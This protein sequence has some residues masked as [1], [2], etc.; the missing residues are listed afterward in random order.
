[1]H[2]VLSL[3]PPRLALLLT[4]CATSACAHTP[5]PVAAKEPAPMTDPTAAPAGNPHLSVEEVGKRFLRLLDSIHTRDDITKERIERVMGVPL[6][7]ATDGASYYIV[8]KI[9]EDWIFSFNF[10]LDG[11]VTKKGVE[12]NFVNRHSRFADMKSVCPLNFDYYHNALKEMGF[13]AVDIYGEI[14][15]LVSWRYYRNDIAVSIV[16]QNIIPGEPTELCV[17]S[18]GTLN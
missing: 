14:N 3:L 1:M 8:Q 4:L 18:I 2:N 11:V 9:N 17:S 13:N 15:Q 6:S 12:L 10:Y 7:L 5:L 16:P